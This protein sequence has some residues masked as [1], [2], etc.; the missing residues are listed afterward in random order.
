MAVYISSGGL[1]EG[2][3]YFG[4][5]EV[6]VWNLQCLVGLPEK[7]VNNL[8]DQFDEGVIPDLLR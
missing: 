5:N 6:E 4:T 1:I 3:T 7:Y 2:I 8:A